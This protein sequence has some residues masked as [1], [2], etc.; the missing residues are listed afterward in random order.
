MTMPVLQIGFKHTWEKN[1]ENYLYT[2]GILKLFS[3]LNIEHNM[4]T[5][6]QEF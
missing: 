4:L 2:Y 1:R 5:E 6:I 3:S